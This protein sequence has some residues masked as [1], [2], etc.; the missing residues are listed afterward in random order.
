[1]FSSLRD[2]GTLHAVWINLWSVDCRLTLWWTLAL[3]FGTALHLSLFNF[4]TFSE[5]RKIW[6]LLSIRVNRVTTTMYYN[7]FI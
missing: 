3:S 6:L 1:M 7:I 4:R 5:S 2:N